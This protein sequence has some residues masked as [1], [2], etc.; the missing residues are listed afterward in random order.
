MKLRKLSIYTACALLLSGTAC[1]Y[2]EVEDSQDPNRA[3][4]ES[5]ANPSRSQ[6][7]QLVVGVVAQMRNSYGSNAPYNRVTGVLGREIYVLATNE[8]KWYNDLLGARPLDDISF[9]SVGAYNQISLARRAA[10]NLQEASQRSTFLSE[11][12]KKGVSG[13]ANTVQA[14]SML[15]LL[16]LMGENGIRIEYGDPN[17]PRNPGPGPFVNYDAALTEIRRLLDVAGT[18]LA[19]AGDELAFALPGGF[20]GFDDPESL[21][22]FNRALTARVA[23]Y[24]EDWTGALAALDESF[25]NLSAA[26]PA[27]LMVGPKHTFGAAPDVFNFYFQNPNANSPTL[28]FVHPSFLAN[29]EPGDRRVAEKTEPRTSPRTLGDLTGTHDPTLYTTNTTPISIIRNE[30]LLLIYAEAKIQ[31]GQYEDAI[32]ALN[33]IRTVAGGLTPYAGSR[34]DKEALISEM[35][36]QRQYSLWY[37]GHRWIDMRRYNRLNQLP[38]DRTGDQVWDRLRVPFNETAWGGTL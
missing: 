5:I 2:F 9:Y 31:L 1:S 18:E 13:F 38:L 6:I 14:W 7:G 27:D 25:L 8:S 21:R 23:V 37:E 24:Q 33:T 22:E 34:T 20:A 35:L 19:G 3:A 12:E 28:A 32:S 36:K 10:Q 29:A 4:I 16:N 17:D 15:H 30:E 26:T 11:E